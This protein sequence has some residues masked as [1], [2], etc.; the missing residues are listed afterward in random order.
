LMVCSSVPACR[1]AF[2]RPLSGLAGQDGSVRPPRLSSPSRCRHAA[3]PA[4]CASRACPSAPIS[5]VR[6]RS[7]SPSG[8]HA[9]VTWR[10]FQVNARIFCRANLGAAGR[11]TRLEIPRHPRGNGP[12][13]AMPPHA[14]RDFRSRPTYAVDSSIA[15]A[16]SSGGSADEPGRSVWCAGPRPRRGTG[17]ASLSLGEIVASV[18]RRW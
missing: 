17:T 16:A 10:P 15:S 18:P 14:R 7:S 13:T 2:S 11:R 1:G 5:P 12:V 9:S 6:S 4:T 8:G 3:Q